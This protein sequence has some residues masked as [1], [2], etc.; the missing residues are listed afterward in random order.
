MNTIIGLYF[1]IIQKYLYIYFYFI[2]FFCLQGWGIT[3]S[4][5]LLLHRVLLQ[6]EERSI[7]YNVVNVLDNR[8][9][10][11]SLISLAGDTS[12]MYQVSSVWNSDA[13][14]ESV[15]NALYNS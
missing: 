4:H 2:I 9:G 10:L 8:T 13:Q 6:E 11:H 14:L 7:Y 15:C 1:N 5:F 3:A 12:W